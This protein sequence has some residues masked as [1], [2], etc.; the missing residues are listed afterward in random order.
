[1]PAKK[2]PDPFAEVRTQT[3]RHRAQHGCGAYPFEDGAILGVIAAAV[4]VKRVLELRCA[5][6]YTAL[7]F[8]HGANGAII[9]TIEFD[10]ATFIRAISPRC[11]RG[12]LPDTISLSSM[13]SPRRRTICGRSRNS[14]ARA[15]C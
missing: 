8:A 10:P 15:A 13:G 14:F 4:A 5:L 2:S 6:G 3:L 11:C 7:W 9:D 1:M 12:W